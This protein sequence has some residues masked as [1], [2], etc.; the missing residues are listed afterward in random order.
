MSQAAVKAQKALG[1]TSSAPPES[2]DHPATGDGDPDRDG[3][4]SIV[5]HQP[6]QTSVVRVSVHG[7][8][9]AADSK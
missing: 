6:F 1:K 4:S 7:Q 8:E 3:Q 5:R 9:H 2:T